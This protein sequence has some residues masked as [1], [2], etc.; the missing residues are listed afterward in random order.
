MTK[1]DINY[2]LTLKYLAESAL[3]KGKLNGLV[4]VCY[5]NERPLQGLVGLLDWRFKG[6]ISSYFSR[7]F[8]K[9]SLGECSYIP[10]RKNDK[11]YH[12]I[13]IGG[14]K[15]SK[16]GKRLQISNQAILNLK[17]NLKTL[18]LDRI[19]ASCIDFGDVDE[20]YFLK[21]MKGVPIWI[22]H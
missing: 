10:I 1:K 16:P 2:K 5:E 9:G 6:E 13:L 4:A 8:L 14:G 18:K 3:F 22:A 11:I 19:G 21:H 15:I 20:S 17:K 7:G 12:I